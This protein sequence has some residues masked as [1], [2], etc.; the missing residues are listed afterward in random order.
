MTHEYHRN[1]ITKNLVTLYKWAKINLQLSKGEIHA[2]LEKMVQAYPD[3]Y[4][5]W[6]VGTN[7]SET[8]W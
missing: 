6:F 7:V 4:V 8:S 5:G 3:E 1:V 2:L